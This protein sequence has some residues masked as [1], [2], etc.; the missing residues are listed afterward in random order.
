[1]VNY[2]K[3]GDDLDIVFNLPVYLFPFRT[4]RK[5]PPCVLRTSTTQSH[6]LK[7]KKKQS[8]P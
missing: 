6:T 5:N 4:A 2:A 1:M 3:F 7:K 8:T